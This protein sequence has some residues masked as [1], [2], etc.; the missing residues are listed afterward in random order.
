MIEFTVHHVLLQTVFR[1]TVAQHPT[2]LWLHIKYFAVV[3]LESQIIGAGETGRACTNDG[4]LLA[5]LRILDE[6]DR[7]IKQTYFGGM[8]MHTAD[9]DFFLNQGTTA[10]LL[11]WSRAGET[12]NIGEGQ[13]FFD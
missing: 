6:W 12:K 7:R 5:R 11:T 2:W 10:G 3:A 8:T 13:H 1:N 4:N 9:G